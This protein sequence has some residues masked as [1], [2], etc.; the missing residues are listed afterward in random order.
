MITP[1]KQTIGQIVYDLQNKPQDSIEAG[2]L[3]SLEEQRYCKELEKAIALG[4]Q[5]FEGDFYI[6]VMLK[7][8]KLYE[9]MLPRIYAIPRTTCPTPFYAQDAYKYKRATGDIAYLWSVPNPDICDYL[10]QNERVL[11]GPDKDLY[12]FVL[13]HHDG[14]LLRLA[15]ELNGEEPMTLNLIKPK[16]IYTV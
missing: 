5:E 4:K 12:Q 3:M 6:E 13:Q 8:E 14:T 15:N 1:A 7:K 10:E 16:R 11:E 2:D 9:N